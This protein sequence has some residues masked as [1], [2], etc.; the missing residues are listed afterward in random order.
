MPGGAEHLLPGP[1]EQRVVDHDDQRC[2]R[3][4]QHRNDDVGQS[5]AY[6]VG[7]P[8]RYG[9]EPVR[10][11]VVPHPRQAGTQKHPADGAPP[12]LRDQADDQG[13]ERPVP[14]CGETRPE[15]GQQGGQ[16]GY[17]E[18]RGIGGSL[19]YEGESDTVDAP[20]AWGGDQDQAIS[21]HTKRSVFN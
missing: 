16:G 12:G 20:L 15:R 6:L 10:P 14:R 11:R 3:V 17:V 4:E 7:A 9:E 18:V 8:A 1:L 13:G 2:V 19:S 5:E 21:N